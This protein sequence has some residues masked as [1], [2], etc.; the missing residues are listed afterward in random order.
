MICKEG[1]NLGTIEARDLSRYWWGGHRLLKITPISN[2]VGTHLWDETIWFE[3]D[4]NQCIP[5]LYVF[6]LIAQLTLIISSSH[7]LSFS[8]TTTSLYILHCVYSWKIINLGWTIL[9]TFLI[10]SFV[11]CIILDNFSILVSYIS[12]LLIVIVLY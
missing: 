9:L 12:I 1:A 5:A 4:T 11:H 3:D 6:V 10:N 8:F 7:L 2:T